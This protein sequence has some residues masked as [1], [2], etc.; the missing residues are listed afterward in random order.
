[1]TPD[2]FVERMLPAGVFFRLPRII[3][4][5]YASHTGDLFRLPYMCGGLSAPPGEMPSA[6]KFFSF[7]IYVVGAFRAPCRIYSNSLT[8]LSSRGTFVNSDKSTQ[9]RRKP[10]G[11]DPLCVFVQVPPAASHSRTGQTVQM[12]R[13]SLEPG[14]AACRTFVGCVFL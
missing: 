7:T 9:K 6:G 11:L 2:S 1:M 8:I 4:R 12:R 13:L 3:R 10:Y 5:K 14:S